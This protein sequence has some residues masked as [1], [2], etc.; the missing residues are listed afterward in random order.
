MI[1][2]AAACDE[3]TGDASKKLYVMIELCHTYKPLSL[4]RTEPNVERTKINTSTIGSSKQV[5]NPLVVRGKDRLPYL[6]KASWMEKELEKVKATKKK[7]TA[8]GKHRQI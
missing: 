5:L 4:T 8:K 3:N 7:V 6:R 1:A 2:Q